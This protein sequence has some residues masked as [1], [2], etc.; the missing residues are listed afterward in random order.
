M[1]A[2]GSAEN[3]ESRAPERARRS[4]QPLQVPE[5]PAQ[6]GA[7][8]SGYSDS[9]R[10]GA[11]TLPPSLRPGLAPPPLC[12]PLPAG[13]R[14]T[15]PGLGSR[16]LRVLCSPSRRSAGFWRPWEARGRREDRAPR[17]AAEVVSA[18]G[19]LRC[20]L[21]KVRRAGDAGL[22]DTRAACPATGAREGGLA[23]LTWA[24]V[25]SRTTGSRESDRDWGCWEAPGHS[26]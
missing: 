12:T 24:G 17:H 19:R 23:A 18:G 4:P 22:K 25:S 10:P 6:R 3:R 2:A 8:D 26:S 5:R 9:A 7:A 11:P 14:W 16:P 21:Q 13:L 15:L 20:A 1:E